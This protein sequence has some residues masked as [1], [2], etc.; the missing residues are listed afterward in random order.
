MF[1]ISSF[2]SFFEILV[3]IIIV[4]R[5]AKVGIFIIDVDVRNQTL[6]NHKNCMRTMNHHFCQ[7]PVAVGFL[8]KLKR[9]CSIVNIVMSVRKY[10]QSKVCYFIE[11][12]LNNF[13]TVEAGLVRN[14][15]SLVVINFK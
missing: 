2:V 15:Y 6:I 4:R 5:L 13:D 11:K 9:F 14:N 12:C 1:F 8:A 10:S 3:A 7:M